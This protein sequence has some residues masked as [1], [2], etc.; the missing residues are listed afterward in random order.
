[1]LQRQTC[2]NVPPFRRH[3]YLLQHA[4]LVRVATFQQH[5]SPFYLLHRSLQTCCN[6][7]PFRQ[8]FYL[9][10]HA[11]LVCVAT[12]QQH[13]SPFYLLHRSL[14]TCCNIPPFRQHF[15]FLQ[16]TLL[17]CFQLPYA[18]SLI[19]ALIRCNTAPAL[20]HQTHSCCHRSP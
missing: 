14:Q 3:F 7:P 9:L 10:Q 13:F 2:C 1:M 20:S 8:H 19:T 16:H 12:F 4:L 18:Y 17:V 11:L 5:F 15:Y 6:I